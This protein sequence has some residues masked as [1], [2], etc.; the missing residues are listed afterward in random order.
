MNSRDGQ[1]PSNQRRLRLRRQTLRRMTDG[2][3]GAVG[4]GDDALPNPKS[5]IWTG[6]GTDGSGGG[7]GGGNRDYVCGG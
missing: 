2:E 5:N 1:N 3:L 6:G 4:G 7:D